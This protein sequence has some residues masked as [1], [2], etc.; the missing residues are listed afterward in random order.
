MKTNKLITFVIIGLVIIALLM[1]I[2]LNKTTDDNVVY[3]SMGPFDQSETDD[4][5]SIT[6]K[7]QIETIVQAIQ[8]KDIIGGN[9]IIST[10]AY[11]TK[12]YVKL[13]ESGREY[14]L[15]ADEDIKVYDGLIIVES[16]NNFQYSIP[17]RYIRGI[18]V[19]LDEYTAQ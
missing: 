10:Y 7:E 8:N 13:S 15:F 12:V 6:D 4:I 1:I 5:F 3:L 16:G 17:K 19:I 2:N 18:M 9:T 11:K 14:V